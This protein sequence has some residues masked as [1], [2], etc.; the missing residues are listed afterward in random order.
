MSHLLA[1][2][3]CSLAPSFDRFSARAAG[4]WR[5]A[6]YTWSQQ[7]APGAHALSVAPGYVTV[8][9]SSAASTET[10][11]RSCGGA[12]QGLRET[13]DGEERPAVT[14][15]RADDGLVYFD[16][17]SWTRVPV[18]LAAADDLLCHSGAFGLSASVSHERLRQRVDLA[19]VGGAPVIADVRVESEAAAAPAAAVERLLRERRLQVVTEARA[20]EGGAAAKMITAHAPS[21]SAWSALRTRWSVSEESIPGGAELVPSASDGV[22]YLPG[23]LWVEVRNGGAAAPLASDRTFAVVIGSLCTESAVVKELI[24]NYR[25]ENMELQTVM[26]REISACEDL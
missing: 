19:M 18:R 10:V 17:G 23:G 8:P 20:W 21:N 1:A 24:H 11:M 4:D 3:A 16:D 9:R 2:L 22:V 7:E 25:G 6:S 12:V 26:L 13:H 15:N 14:L 5:G